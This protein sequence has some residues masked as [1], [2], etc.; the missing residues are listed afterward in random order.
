MIVKFGRYGKFIACSNYPACRNTKSYYE[1]IGVAC[2]ECGHDLVERRTRKHRIFYGCITYPECEYSVW[3]RPLPTPCPLCG[4]MLV[5]DKKGWVKCT[6]CE[7]RFEREKIAGAEL[8][9]A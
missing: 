7:E 9:T 3:N 8:V 2:P 4:G 1:K 6:K 5:E